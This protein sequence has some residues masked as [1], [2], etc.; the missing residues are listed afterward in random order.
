MLI[1]M[2]GA[3]RGHRKQCLDTP[4]HQ[5]LFARIYSSNFQVCVCMYEFSICR[6]HLGDALSST[7]LRGCLYDFLDEWVIEQE[8]W[9]IVAVVEIELRIAS[10]ST[11]SIG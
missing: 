5:F 4:L 3:R 11:H 6:L 2:P 7:C 9:T 10:N 1:T 8:C